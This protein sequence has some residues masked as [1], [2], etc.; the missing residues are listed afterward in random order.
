MHFVKEDLKVVV[1][2]DP[3]YHR[4]TEVDMLIGDATQCREKL[5]WEPTTPLSEGLQK[6]IDWFRSINIDDYQPPT[7]NYS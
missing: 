4:P 2:I 3:K 6:T 7:P 1:K 5:N